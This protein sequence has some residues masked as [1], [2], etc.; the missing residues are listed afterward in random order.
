MTQ[1]SVDA[2]QAL[3]AMFVQE[4]A[5][6]DA[7][8]LLVR[9]KARFES[10]HL[11][12]VW[13]LL[14]AQVYAAASERS[15]ADAIAAEEPDPSNRKKIHLAI[16]RVTANSTNEFKEVSAALE[17][18]YAD[19][20]RPEH[21]FDLCEAW[22]R[23]GKTGSVARHAEE[24]MEHFPTPAALAMAAEAAADAKR[25]ELCLKLLKHHHTLSTMGSF[26]RHFVALRFKV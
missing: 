17:E 8:N 5:T 3:V 14:Q 9:E 15:A 7:R 10:Q 22:M 19:G 12:F 26:H 21:L 13:R 16:L 6:Q 18:L 4:G 1:L 23:T 24:L 11:G 20:Q 2:T 25:P